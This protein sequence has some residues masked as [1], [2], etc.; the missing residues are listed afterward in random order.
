[1]QFQNFLPWFELPSYSIH[2][3]CSVHIIICDSL[4]TA[5]LCAMLN[6]DIN[7]LYHWQKVS[8]LFS[9]LSPPPFWSS[10][11]GPVRL[12]RDV[13]SNVPNLPG[14]IVQQQ[15]ISNHNLWSPLALISIFGL[16]C[17]VT[18]PVTRISSSTIV[19]AHKEKCLAFSLDLPRESKFLLASLKWLSLV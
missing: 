10:Q 6:L 11:K 14:E 12:C 8:G 15:S 1:M 2:V 7:C 3:D 4:H 5:P 9:L 18:V 19:W 13:S 17:H 16:A